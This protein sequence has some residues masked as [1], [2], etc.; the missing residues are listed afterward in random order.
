[1]VYCEENILSFLLYKSRKS[2]PGFYGTD[3]N[4]WQLLKGEK[5]IKFS[6]LY[7]NS[8]STGFFGGGVAEETNSQP[9][10]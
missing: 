6:L 9:R 7:V 1:M 5:V 10:R 3:V 4:N 2:E 8:T